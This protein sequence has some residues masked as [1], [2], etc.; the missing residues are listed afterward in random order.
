[1][2]NFRTSN[3]RLVSAAGAEVD[4]G[5]EKFLFAGVEGGAFYVEQRVDPTAYRLP[6]VAGAFGG[7]YAVSVGGVVSLSVSL[8]CMPSTDFS[9]F[10]NTQ[11]FNSAVG[12]QSFT[13]PFAAVQ[14]AACIGISGTATLVAFGVPFWAMA[15]GALSG[16]N[17]VV[18]L[19]AIFS[20][21]SALGY[22]LSGMGDTTSAGGTLTMYMGEVFAAKAVDPYELG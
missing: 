6:I 4:V 16:G 20:Q 14:A 11:R 18:G 2:P 17:P 13:G 22:I 5:F 3:W 7:G 8:P 19:A 12:L 1:M 15:A 9:I 21:C 10:E